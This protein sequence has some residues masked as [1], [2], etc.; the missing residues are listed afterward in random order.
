M[1]RV[2]GSMITTFR[3]L[4]KNIQE[5]K[6]KGFKALKKMYNKVILTILDHLEIII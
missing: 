2:S 5:L 1:F 4:K 3:I 6:K